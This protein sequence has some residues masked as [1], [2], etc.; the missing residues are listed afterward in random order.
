MNFVLKKLQELPD[1]IPQMIAAAV[2]TM[3]V[4]LSHASTSS[5]VE[6]EANNAPKRRYNIPA[7][8]Q[9]RIDSNTVVGV[10]RARSG[11]AAIDVTTGGDNPHLRPLTP[12][13]HLP[14][15]W[16][17]AIYQVI[18]GQV[19]R[20]LAFN[21]ASAFLS[22]QLA[23]GPV[24]AY[25]FNK[26]ARQAGVSARALREAKSALGVGRYGRGKQ[27]VLSK[28]PIPKP[29]PAPRKPRAPRDS[30]RDVERLRKLGL[31]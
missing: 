22:E 29:A 25:G 8:L 2:P 31:E 18:T 11:M 1:A 30:K 12:V 9:E 19:R 17:G 7:D 21:K 10:V 26:V 4:L 14:L 15:K 27:A 24:S 5:P 13:D 3:Q 28:T 16:R 23:G 20:T 6:R